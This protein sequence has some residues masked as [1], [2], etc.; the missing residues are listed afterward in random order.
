MLRSHRN[1]IA[2]APSAPIADPHRGRPSS[3]E[4]RRRGVELALIWAAED[5]AAEAAR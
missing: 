4:H 3:P 5:A 1:R 2:P